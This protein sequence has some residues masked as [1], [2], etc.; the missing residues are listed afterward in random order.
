MKHYE[1][2][3]TGLFWNSFDKTMLYIQNR[4]INP[5]AA[6][7]YKKLFKEAVIKL[8]TIAGSLQIV[9]DDQARF[10]KIRKIRVK[11]YSILYYVNEET[12]TAY[13]LGIVHNSS[14]WQSFLK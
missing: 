13:V 1:V 12:S 14:N 8:E 6:E 2:I 7:R 3:L 5:F 4:L 10:L 11:R 9:G